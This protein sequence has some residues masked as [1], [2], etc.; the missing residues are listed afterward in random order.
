MQ[1]SCVGSS[2]RSTFKMRIQRPLG[3]SE[4]RRRLLRVV[5]FSDAALENGSISCARP[6]K[7]H[8][9][10][11]LQPHSPTVPQSHSPTAPQPHSPTAPQSHSPTAPQS[12]SATVPQS[13]SPTVPQPHSTTP[14]PHSTTPQRHSATAPQSH[15]PTAQQPTHCLFYCGHWE[16]AT[17]HPLQAMW[18]FG[19]AQGVCRGA[20]GH[21]FCEAST[22]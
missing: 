1:P 20:Q 9:S 7:P 13:H 3:Q 8:S 12:H 11:A 15:S 22:K 6:P 4:G 2:G 16:R 10:T 5:V 17:T 21:T 19:G 18:E 14:Q